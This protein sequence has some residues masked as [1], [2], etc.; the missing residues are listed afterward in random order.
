MGYWDINHL[1]I[2]VLNK[3]ISWSGSHLPMQSD[4][5]DLSNYKTTA[6]I[7]VPLVRWMNIQ[8][9]VKPK[10][11]TKLPIVYAFGGL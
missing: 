1:V 4:Q 8:V 10:T 9:A 7:F 3:D 11:I 6:M 5:E 2:W